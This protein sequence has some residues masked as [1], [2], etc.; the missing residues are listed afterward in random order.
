MNIYDFDGTIYKGD[1][2]KDI[3]KYGLFHYPSLTYKA[4]KNARKKKKDYD[5]NLVP[6]EV[7]KQELL[8][9]IFKIPNYPKFIEDFVSSHMKKIKPFYLSR[10]TEND[11]ILSASY[12]L[13]V[14]EFARKLGIKYV[15]ATRVN[16]DGEIIGKNCKGEEKVRRFK[17]V[18]PNAIVSSA[19]SDSS[20]DI[21]MLELCIT[22][23]VVE[24]NKFS[25]YRKG[26]KFKNN[27]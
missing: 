7:V 25:T 12:D 27:K 2:C 26:Y 13:W 5:N 17:E 23:F 4:L 19:F 15:I 8:S 10:K 16:S 11:V 1:S 21:P 14:K 24:G 20:V 18:Y 9:F 6:F 3:V 22:A